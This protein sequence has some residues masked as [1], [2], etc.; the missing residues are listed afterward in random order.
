M[1]DNAANTNVDDSKGS[2]NGTFIDVDGNPNTNTHHV[3][4]K[5]GT[6]ALDFSGG[7]ETGNYPYIDCGNGSDLNL[8]T[9]LSVECWINPDTSQE[10]AN[11]RGIAG[12][13][14]S[15]D[16]SSNWSW[17]IRYGSPDSNQ[18]GFQANDD[19]GGSVWVTAKQNLNNGTW[20]HIVVTFDGTNLKFYLNKNNTDSDVLVGNITSNLNKLLIGNEGWNNC[21]DGQI[22]N[23]RIYNR[24]L[25]QAEIN[26]LYNNGDGI[27]DLSGCYIKNITGCL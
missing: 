9:G 22:D 1:N 21:F 24:A 4:G 25:T 6:G 12:K 7:Y 15:Y 3:A 5:V 17:Q 19:G 11:N 2:N 18:L 27:E 8:T 20:Y 13:V 10:D 23:F 16:A 26:A 14:E